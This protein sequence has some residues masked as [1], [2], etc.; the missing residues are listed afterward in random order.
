MAQGLDILA[1]PCDQFKHQEPG[2]DE[3]IANFAKGFGANFT[4]FSKT[5]VN[6]R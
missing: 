1:F 6:G 5:I 3:E 4:V 2:T